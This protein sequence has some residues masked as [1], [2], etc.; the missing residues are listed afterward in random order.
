[1]QTLGETTLAPASRSRVGL[2]LRA[3]L[4][5]GALLLFALLAA[6]ASRALGPDSAHVTG[7]NS[8]SGVPVMMCNAREWSLFHFYYYGQDRFGAWPFLA[9]RAVGRMLGVQVMPAHLHAWMTVWLLAGAF[10]FAGLA[11]GLR[12][13]AAGLY[14]AVVLAIPGLRSV[15]F[16][17]AQVYPW[18]MT[19]L[20]VA[21]W[22]LRRQGDQAAAPEAPSRAALYRGRASTFLLSFLAIWTSTVSGPLLV[23]VGG[24]EA[25]RVKLLAPERFP[26]WRALRRWGETLLLVGSAYLLETLIRSA[27]HRYSKVHYG[28][29][30]RTNLGIDLQYL[31]QNARAILGQVAQA[32]TLPLLLIGTVGALGAAVV[33]WRALRT[34]ATMEAARVDEATL[35]LGAWVLAAAHLPLLIILNHVRLND[36]SG[37]YFTPLYFFGALAGAV[38]LALG[39]ALVPGLARARARLLP[40]VGLVAAA[41]SAW[42]LPAPQPTR[43]YLELTETAERIARRLPGAPLLGGYWN[44]Y[45]FPP[46]Q[47]EG[48]LVPMPCEGQYQRTVWLTRDLI[49]H[50]RVLVE[51]VDCP[52]A[53]TA[54]APAPWFFQHGVLLRL[55][56]PRW[57]AGA[58][59]TFSLYRN[60][61][62]DSQPHTAEPALSGWKPCQPG[63]S[64]TLSFPPR[65]QAHVFVALAGTEYPVT[66]TA[67]PLAAEGP[68]LAP[69]VL[70]AQGKLHEAR[71]EGGGALLRGVR[72]TASPA[73]AD[74]EKMGACRAEASFVLDAAADAAP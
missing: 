67:E 38:T 3:L 58:G 36:Y 66:L 24:V 54:E 55:E 73:P 1:M 22:S 10:V 46:L 56:Q 30:Y 2:A 23:L 14:F 39:A 74:S 53:G 18:Q 15:L 8:D 21:W 16:E 61:S 28:H 31:G 51:P 27:Y 70:R 43:E 71:L 72:L 64:L 60:A 5:M 68:T 6:K 50:P 59:R 48:A 19:A 25:L 47:T 42:A 33:A 62:G 32:E 20:L 4:G 57:D 45:V 9:A 69:V 29:R 37:R 34:R 26:R 40:A 44:T 63:A 13:L 17:L 12:V 7:L 41:G 35:V 52:G 11:R 65:A 49:R